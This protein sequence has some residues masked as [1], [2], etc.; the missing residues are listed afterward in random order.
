MG[1]LKISRDGI[2]E[3]EEEK[4][5]PNDGSGDGQV[6]AKNVSFMEHIENLGLP[7]PTGN[8]GGKRGG[9]FEPMRVKEH[10]TPTFW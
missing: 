2:K 6:V 4:K 7:K 8:E 3:I 10:M 1:E 5:E 9:N